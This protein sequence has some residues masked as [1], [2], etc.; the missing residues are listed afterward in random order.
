M[1]PPELIRPEG[2]PPDLMDMLGGTARALI[3]AIGAPRAAIQTALG[4]GS[5]ENFVQGLE[6]TERWW[7]DRGVP[8]IGGAG[9]FAVDVATDPLS[10]IGLGLPAR[11][12][13]AAQA[14]NLAPQIIAGLKLLDRGDVF[15]Q[16]AINKTFELGWKG[17]TS[18]LRVVPTFGHGTVMRET[19]ATL[20]SGVER[21]IVQPETPK[22]LYD[23]LAG[24]SV[25]SV[26]KDRLRDLRD[27]V[28]RVRQGYPLQRAISDEDQVAR[29]MLVHRYEPGKFMQSKLALESL[30]TGL[31]KMLNDAPNPMAQAEAIEVYRETVVANLYPWS[32]ALTALRANP[33]VPK[34]ALQARRMRRDPAN[35]AYA[36]AVNEVAVNYRAARDVIE[37]IYE[38]WRNVPVLPNAQIAASN[39]NT[40]KAINDIQDNALTQGFMPIVLGEQTV[41]G[42][43]KRYIGRFPEDT[44][45]DRY[46]EL[47][48][49]EQQLSDAV[50][51]LRS[52]ATQ[53][54]IEDISGQFADRRQQL[55]FLTNMTNKAPDALPGSLEDLPTQLYS[56]MFLNEGVLTKYATAALKGRQKFEQAL[57]EMWEDAR[58][59]VPYPEINF[60]PGTTGDQ[61][62][63]E[64]NSRLQSI[65]QS[66]GVQF[67][68]ITGAVDFVQTGGAA[69]L[70]R[71][72]TLQSLDSMIKRF[73]GADLLAG[74]PWD[75]AFERTARLLAK[76]V[77]YKAPEG[78]L[79]FIKDINNLMKENMLLSITY[80]L[81]NIVSGT[82]MARMEGVPVQ[83]QLRS[84]AGNMVNAVRG[85][86]V[87]IPHLDALVAS[88]GMP[89]PARATAESSAILD[90]TS[91]SVKDYL[92]RNLTASQR[93][94]SAKLAG[95]GGALGATSAGIQAPA[96][97]T[98]EERASIIITGAIAGASGGALLPLAS[99]IVLQKFVRGTEDVLR[100]EAYFTGAFQAIQDAK[101][102][103]DQ[104]I[105]DAFA[106]KTRLRIPAS[107]SSPEVMVRQNFTPTGR[108][109]SNQ[110]G[111]AAVRSQFDQAFQDFVD[112]RAGLISPDALRSALLYNG[113]NHKVAQAAA[114]NWRNIL[115]AASRK[116]EELSTR[117]HFDYSK[118]TNAEEAARMIFPFSTW[119]IRALPFYVRHMSQHPLILTSMLEYQQLAEKWRKDRGLTGRTAGALWMPAADHL[120]SIALGHPVQTFFN[121]LRTIM[122]FS[123]SARNAAVMDPE[124]TPMSFIERMLQTA[125][126]PGFHP[127]INTA[128][129]IAGARGDEPSQ[130]IPVRQAPFV[131]GATGLMG[132][133]RGQG[134]DLA[135]A[136]RALETK[137]RRSLMGQDPQDPALATTLNRIDELALHNTGQPINVPGADRLPYLEAKV[138]RRG[139]IW[140]AAAAETSRD[141]NVRSMASFIYQPLAPQAVVTPEEARI[142]EAR[143]QR[144]LDPKFTDKLR[145][146]A[147]K[148]PDRLMSVAVTDALLK[149][150]D[151]MLQP[152]RDQGLMKPDEYPP[153]ID[154]LFAIPTAKNMNE[155]AKMI[156]TELTLRNPLYGGYGQTGS[157]GE[158]RLQNA[159]SLFMSQRSLLPPEADIMRRSGFPTRGTDV[160]L[161]QQGVRQRQEAVKEGDAELREYLAA[162][163]LDPNI[164]VEE[165]L[166]RRRARR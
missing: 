106:S 4:G 92:K 60:T 8:F 120:W 128:A 118:L 25:E 131:A 2:Q 79:A 97:A 18:P 138:N 26:F 80:P 45:A 100:K 130:G 35:E 115:H 22:N 55:N 59:G 64:F 108:P 56:D 86:P 137:V 166:A 163:Q 30:D 13:Q 111:E 129:R 70:I 84:L 40:I 21:R 162:K 50:D 20:P 39:R 96:D 53:V 165:F 117:I 7:S 150:T 63:Q 68:P 124:E 141:R 91:Q 155:L 57:K 62:L 72:D 16:Q 119:A 93:F 61:V 116:G 156:H 135:A 5:L 123:E 114:Q 143:L 23:L 49:R 46:A 99:K 12:A 94:G 51:K 121:P 41:P 82:L 107:G 151:H 36:E 85:Q 28:E 48:Q 9:R 47:V 159:L 66:I 157:P 33:A 83:R 27:A 11:A 69:G 73:P 153:E 54:S 144:V 146:E 38:K 125:G 58:P 148:N 164:N 14:A 105:S 95:A 142:R 127:A 98:P 160:G 42:T 103:L 6:E 136:P 122:P 134:V 139:P 31:R 109:I 29:N 110:A 71:N 88:T 158:A 149:A 90:I 75:I 44:A 140:D 67:K 154:A 1:P 161:A 43:A 32:D 145:D 81:V 152:W 87:V 104:I 147:A 89:V 34:S 74:D 24:Q 133:N 101:P 77:G 17:V 132:V 19:T 3:N 65:G 78:S 126:M 15:A 113:V 52:P 102:A 37:D 10:Y 112:G 76:E